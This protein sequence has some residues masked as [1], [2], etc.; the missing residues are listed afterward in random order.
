MNEINIFLDVI[1]K[2]ANVSL[3]GRKTWK[4]NE[5]PNTYI[6]ECNTHF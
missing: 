5:M 3:Q 4:E 6:L 2:I 1:D